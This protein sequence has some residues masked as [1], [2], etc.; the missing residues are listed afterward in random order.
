MPELYAGLPREARNFPVQYLGANVPQV[1][2]AGSIFMFL[3]AILGLM[4]DAPHE[5]L[6]VDPCL[7]DWLPDITI[8]DL[9]VGRRKFDIRF[10]RQNAESRFEILSGERSAVSRQSFATGPTLACNSFP[11]TSRK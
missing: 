7:P 4:P 8:R 10:W 2:A 3:Q 6:C 11:R 5:C 9:R 1:W